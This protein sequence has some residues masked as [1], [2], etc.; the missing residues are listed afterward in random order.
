M[1]TREKSMLPREAYVALERKRTLFL[2]ED[3]LRMKRQMKKMWT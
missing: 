2:I 3:S 1:M